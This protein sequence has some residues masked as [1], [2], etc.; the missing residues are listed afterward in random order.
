VFTAV[1]RKEKN[2]L[3]GNDAEKGTWLARVSACAGALAPTGPPSTQPSR[4]VVMFSRTVRWA[5]RNLGVGGTPSSG[6]LAGIPQLFLLLFIFAIPF[7]ALPFGV[8]DAAAEARPALNPEM[9]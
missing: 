8:G 6:N 5:D 1:A 3:W 7:F 2:F 9:T 4:S